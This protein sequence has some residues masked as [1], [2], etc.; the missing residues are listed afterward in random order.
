MIN[1]FEGVFYALFFEIEVPAE[2]NVGFPQD[3]Y[4]GS[5]GREQLVHDLFRHG[6]L[7]ATVLKRD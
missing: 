7:R 3:Q 6:D 5:P 1:V 4:L 2:T